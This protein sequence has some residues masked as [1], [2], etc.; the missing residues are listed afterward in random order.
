M[1]KRAFTSVVIFCLGLCGRVQAAI[2][3][4]FDASQ[5]YS[6]IQLGSI[7]DTVRS[8]GYLFTYTRDKL[9]TGGGS[10]PIGRPIRIA[11]PEGL[12]AQAITAGSITGPAKF[13][14]RRED[15]DVFGLPAFTAK[16]LANTSGAGAS[17]EIMPQLNGEDAFPDPV[18]FFATGFYGQAF[19]YDTT[20]PAYLGNTFALHDFDAYQISLYVDFALTDLKLDGIIVPEPSSTMFSLGALP[21]LTLIRR[22]RRSR[23]ETREVGLTA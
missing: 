23:F 2:V 5:A 7:S 15:G 16:L 14:I 1:K 9:F 19:S 20:T 6:I 10:D 11:W 8:E 4:F 3:D 12:E 18:M 13:T 21:L 22:R 17:I